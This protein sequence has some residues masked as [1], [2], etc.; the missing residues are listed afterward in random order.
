MPEEVVFE[1]PEKPE[2][3]VEEQEPSPIALFFSS[4]E[5]K[6]EGVFE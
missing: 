6:D 2:I 4:L 5:N 3:E 1:A